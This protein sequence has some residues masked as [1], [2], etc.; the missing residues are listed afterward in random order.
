MIAFTTWAGVLGYS[1]SRESGSKKQIAG[2]T[3]IGMPISCH[4]QI[5]FAVTFNTGSHGN[6][7]K[8]SVSGRACAM[9]RLPW[10]LRV[11]DLF[12]GLAGIMTGVFHCLDAI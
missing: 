12:L 11:H 1:A 7:V 10:T 5:I 2:V 9:E 8:G 3:L 6:I 4:V